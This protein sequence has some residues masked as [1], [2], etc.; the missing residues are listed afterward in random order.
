MF[1][2]HAR[3]GH[4]VER[5]NWSH[6][7]KWECP[8]TT[9]PLSPF[10]PV[11][12]RRMFVWLTLVFVWSCQ[13]LSRWMMQSRDVVSYCTELHDLRLISEPLCYSKFPQRSCIYVFFFCKVSSTMVS[14]MDDMKD[15]TILG[16]GFHA[17]SNPSFHYIYFSNSLCFSLNRLMSYVIFL[18]M[19]E[20]DGLQMHLVD[21]RFNFL[22]C[23]ICHSL[24]KSKLQAFPFFSPPNSPW[25]KQ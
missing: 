25:H 3:P 22:Q 13:N 16:L 9:H 17:L 11:R 2:S 24:L 1:W 6:V 7:F 15:R 19:E 5:G 12:T 4:T 10:S 20:L 14:M 8:S 21:T 18:H 23:G